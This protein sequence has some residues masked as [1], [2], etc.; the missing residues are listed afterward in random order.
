MTNIF[1]LHLSVNCMFT[2]Q[3]GEIP[4]QRIK[5]KSA[6]QQRS[7]SLDFGTSSDQEY[8]L[9]CNSRHLVVILLLP[10]YHFMKINQLISQVL[11]FLRAY[12]FNR[13]H[14]SCGVSRLASIK[15]L[16]PVCTLMHGEKNESERL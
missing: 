10:S 1:R 6:A 11:P 3:L 9:L 2:L 14:A 7:H 15:G 12:Q 5:Y 13:R 8:H 4:P 16:A